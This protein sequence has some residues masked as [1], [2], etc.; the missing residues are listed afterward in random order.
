MMKKSIAALLTI[1]LLLPLAVF[2]AAAGEAPASDV[3]LTLMA[4]QDWIQDAEIELGQKFTDETGI[5]VAYRII[6]SDQ[7]FYL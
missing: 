2:G 1:M 6:P 7:Q 4:S 3:V 5:T